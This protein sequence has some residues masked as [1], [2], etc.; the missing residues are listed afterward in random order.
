MSV[1]LIFSPHPDDETICCG[2]L[3]ARRRAKNEDIY[4]IFMTDGRYGTKNQ[5]LFGSK[6]LIEIRKNEAIKALRILGVPSKNLIFLGFEDSKLI[7]Y[8]NTASKIV[9]SILYEFSP[10]EVYFP[11]FFDTH[12]DHRATN[13][14]ITKSLKC[15]HKNVMKYQYIIHEPI[16]SLQATMN[17]R[18]YYLFYKCIKQKSLNRR[19][20]F[21]DIRSFKEQK[22]MAFVKYE[23][24]IN[25]YLLNKVLNR[26]EEFFY[27]I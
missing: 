13:I 26:D 17:L 5:Q 10:R 19:K 7:S 18:Y 24:Q 27:L 23:S 25:N 1:T 8:V 6:E 20:V 4:V 12:I 15:F 16:L 21:L 14:I 2:G 9:K 3:I 22:V 11:A